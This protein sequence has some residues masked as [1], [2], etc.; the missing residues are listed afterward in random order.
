MTQQNARVINIIAKI[1]QVIVF[2]YSLLWFAFA[3]LSGSEAYGGG[4]HALVKNSPNAIPWLVLLL[5]NVISWGWERTGG[6]LYLIFGI[7]S[8]FF[9]R[10]WKF[11]GVVF[12]LVTLPFM[13]IGILCIFYWSFK[14]AHPNYYA[15]VNKA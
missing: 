7:F 15:R 11:D 4:F 6:I 8:F 12:L 5:I 10:A 13:I 3:L 14:T 1:M 2:I 9:F